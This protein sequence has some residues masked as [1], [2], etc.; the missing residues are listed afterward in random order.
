MP[1]MAV[2]LLPLKLDTTLEM[3][4]LMLDSRTL[5]APAKW[6][7]QPVQALEA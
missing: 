4:E 6:Y 5:Y 3:A 1:S 7:G 2:T